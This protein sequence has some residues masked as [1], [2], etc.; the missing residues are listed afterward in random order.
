[1]SYTSQAACYSQDRSVITSLLAEVNEAVRHSRLSANITKLAP[2]AEEE[3]ALLAEGT[4]IF[5]CDIFFLQMH[6][7][8]RDFGHRSRT[9]GDD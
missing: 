4:S 9:K 7:G 3:V 8:I 6:I 1:M 5:T 2:D